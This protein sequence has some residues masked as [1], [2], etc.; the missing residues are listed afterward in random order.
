[1]QPT[2][3]LHKQMRNHGFLDLIW[4]L[5]AVAVR[6]VTVQLQLAS[7]HRPFYAFNQH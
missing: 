5:Q 6:L 4:M 2:G 3:S 1:M 7:E